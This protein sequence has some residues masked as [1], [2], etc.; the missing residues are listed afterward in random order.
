MKA[1]AD[2][3]LDEF[4]QATLPGLLRYATALT[5]DPHLA[6]DIVQ[7]VLVKVSVRWR[8]IGDLD[9][10]DL[11]VRRMVTNQHVSWR[12]KWEVRFI[13]PS[14]SDVLDANASHVPDASK[15]VTDRHDL[16]HRLGRLPAQQRAVLVLRYLEGL[17]DSEIADVLGTTT[18]TVRSHASRALKRLRQESSQPVEIRR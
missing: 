12:R 8:Q 11:Y 18:T 7:D 6:A 9:R 2:Q 17:E 1:H 13:R 15:Q 16:V 4:L 10:P 5:G 3:R 14:P